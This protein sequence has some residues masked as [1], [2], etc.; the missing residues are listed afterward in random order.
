MPLK[1]IT[2]QPQE[3]GEI[4]RQTIEDVGLLTEAAILIFKMGKIQGIDDIAKP[5]QARDHFARIPQVGRTPFLG[6]LC[7]RYSQYCE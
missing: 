3:N 1:N 2:K 6:L 5:T 4:I 7:T